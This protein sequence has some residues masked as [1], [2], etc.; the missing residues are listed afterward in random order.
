MRHNVI[1]EGSRSYV[2]L[3]CDDWNKFVALHKA[4]EDYACNE[5]LLCIEQGLRTPK[6]LAVLMQALDKLKGHE[7]EN[8]ND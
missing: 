7:Y 3:S 1:V 6:Y 5:Y 2:T 4:A 8:D